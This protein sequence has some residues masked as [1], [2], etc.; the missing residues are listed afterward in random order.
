MRR[1]QVA[2]SKPMRPRN[3]GDDR[4]PGTAEG[5]RTASRSDC[6]GGSVSCAGLP[7]A[8]ANK[9]S[10]GSVAFRFGVDF[11]TCG[12]RSSARAIKTPSGSVVFGLGVEFIGAPCSVQVTTHVLSAKAGKVGN[13]SSLLRYN[14][15]KRRRWFVDLDQS[16]PRR[17]L[18]VTAAISARP[19]NVCG[20]RER[21]RLHH[22]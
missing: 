5:W 17:P 14:F 21:T 18:G 9:R 20:R 10:L 15:A 4:R 12:S 22:P 16:L 2:N 1:M 11:V 8:R 13:L 6:E 19:L 3:A 7:S